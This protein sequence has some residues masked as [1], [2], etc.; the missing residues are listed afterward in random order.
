MNRDFKRLIYIIIGVG[1]FV[2]V[3]KLFIKLLPW[4]IVVG[5]IVYV[6]SKIKSSREQKKLKNN[7]YDKSSYK[8][9]INVNVYETNPEDY[10][11]GEVIDVD[12]EDVDNK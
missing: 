7:T 9:N 4:L 3:A 10:T 11:N 12:Y 5:G 1:I 8:N 6:V 2:M